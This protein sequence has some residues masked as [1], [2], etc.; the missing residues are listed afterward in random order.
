MA[1]GT[2]AT[3]ARQYHQQMVHYCRKTVTFEDSGAVTVGILPA[4]AVIV[5]DL[6]Y[7]V[8]TTAFN[9]GTTNTVHV[10]S[11]ADNDLYATALAAGSIASVKFDE[12]SASNLLS[13]DTTITATYN[14]TGTAATAGSAE[15]VVAY[16]P[17]N[18]G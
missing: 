5:P 10:G 13:A 12:M 2:A 18:D 1:T 15:V 11:S 16:I 8:V 3:A 7:V 14:Q 17:D 6:S 4:G 9:A